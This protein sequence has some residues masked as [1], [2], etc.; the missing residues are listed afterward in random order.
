LENSLE[1]SLSCRPLRCWI[2]AHLEWPAMGNL[3]SSLV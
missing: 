1:R 2:F 3:L